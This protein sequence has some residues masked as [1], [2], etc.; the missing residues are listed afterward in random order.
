[1]PFIQILTYIYYIKKYVNG[2]R[3]L[4]EIIDLLMRDI[5]NKG[6]D[7]LSNKISGHFAKFR[8]LELAFAINRL[9]GLKVVQKK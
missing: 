1:M 6:L 9:R 4:R 3:T 7:V 2:E 5:E 8:S